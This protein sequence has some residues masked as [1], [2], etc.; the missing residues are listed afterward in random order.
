MKWNLQLGK[1]D[2]LP[3]SRGQQ[4]DYS[5]FVWVAL[6]SGSVR[7]GQAEFNRQSATPVSTWHLEADNTGAPNTT[8]PNEEVVGW[9]VLEHPQHPLQPRASAQR[10]KVP[11]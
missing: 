3:K 9:A 5:E 6:R 4:R 11:T 10:R 8:L 1:W 2:A 7:I